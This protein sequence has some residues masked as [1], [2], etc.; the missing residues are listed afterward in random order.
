MGF[1]GLLTF[2]GIGVAIFAIAD[3]VT[4]RAIRLFIDKYTLYGGFLLAFIL[5]LSAKLLHETHPTL[6]IL[7]QGVALCL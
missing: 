7:L 4:R 5:I 2:F 6:D 3:P 1:D